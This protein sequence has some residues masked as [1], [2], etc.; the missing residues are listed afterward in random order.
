MIQKEAWHLEVAG[1]EEERDRLFRAVQDG[2]ITPERFTQLMLRMWKGT[3]GPDEYGLEY[4]ERL[5]EDPEPGDPEG[6]PSV[7]DVYM[8]KEWL[9]HHG[10]LAREI[11]RWY[12]ALTEWRGSFEDHSDY[13]FDYEDPEEEESQHL[14]NL[15]V[16][17]DRDYADASYRKTREWQQV[18][19]EAY[20]RGLRD[21]LIIWSNLS[22]ARFWMQPDRDLPFGESSYRRTFQTEVEFNQ[23]LEGLVKEAEAVADVYSGVHG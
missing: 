16:D 20:R 8:T 18:R 23:Y 5:V 6:T 1:F 14:Y 21:P 7:V 19:W 11:H 12:E 13:D 22:E 15:Q 10:R 3:Q 17:Y 4:L 2:Q 9:Y